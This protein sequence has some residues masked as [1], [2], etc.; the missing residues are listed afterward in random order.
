MV[1][2]GRGIAPTDVAVGTQALLVSLYLHRDP[3]RG[4]LRQRPTGQPGPAPG[5][6]AERSR[7]RIGAADHLPASLTQ[8]VRF[9]EDHAD[10]PIGLTEIAQAARLSPRALQAAF[11]QHLHTTPLAHL[12][13]VRLARA[14]ADLQS[15]RPGDDRTVSVI[16]STWGFSQ[17][18]RFARDYRRQYGVA[19]HHTLDSSA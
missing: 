11:R 19:P 18:S 14:H 2:T 16:A 13:S 7:S 1:L 10:E 12:R 17:L 9:V 15:A 5:P 4:P 6:G 3:G 8:A